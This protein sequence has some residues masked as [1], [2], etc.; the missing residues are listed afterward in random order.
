MVGAFRISYKTSL[1][2]KSSQVVARFDKSQTRLRSRLLHEFKRYKLI[3]ISFFCI[4]TDKLALNE[5]SRANN[6]VLP[7]FNVRK[8]FQVTYM[9]YMKKTSKIIQLQFRT[10][11]YL[12]PS[13]RGQAVFYSRITFFNPTI[14]SLWIFEF[15]ST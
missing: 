12:S 11:L 14:L 9:R 13:D 10:F 15:S 7:S 1:L 8:L 6:K 5:N 2:E 3:L 4:S